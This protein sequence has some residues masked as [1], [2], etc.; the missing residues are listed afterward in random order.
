V[1]VVGGFVQ[2]SSFLGVSDKVDR[3]STLSAVSTELSGEV[4]SDDESWLSTS[5]VTG[6]GSSLKWESSARHR[7]QGRGV[8]IGSFTVS[9]GF[10]VSNGDVPSG[11]YFR[12]ESSLNDIGGQICEISTFSVKH[13]HVLEG[14]KLGS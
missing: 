11:C 6:V 14:H 1:S 10:K 8:S 13:G 4:V 12:N 3:S 9:T 5:V 7:D 2:S